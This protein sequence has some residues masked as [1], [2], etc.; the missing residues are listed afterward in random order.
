MGDI[1]EQIDNLKTATIAE[2]VERY[3]QLFGQ[4]PP[5]WTKVVLIRQLAHKIQEQSLG[6]ISPAAKTRIQE[7]IRIYDPIHRV[8]IKSSTGKTNVGRDI[9]LPVPGSFIVKTYKGK[10]LE[11]KVLEKGFEYNG[12]VY[13]NLTGV[14]KAITGAHW[15]GFVFFGVKGRGR[16]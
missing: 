11:V 8:V 2:L 12:T 7:L 16:R 15:N 9:R 6:G 5:I 14:A 10:R 13:A 3:K 4:K 1:A